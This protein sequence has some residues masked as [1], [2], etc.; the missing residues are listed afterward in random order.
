MQ[1][2][3]RW[4]RRGGLGLL[5]G[6]VLLSIGCGGTGTVSGKV[7]FQDQPLPGGTVIFTNADGKGTKTS[8]IQSDGSYTIEEMPVGQAKIGVE[9]ESINPQG[10]GGGRATPPAAGQAPGRGGPPQS[11]MPPAD[12]VP[13]G[14]DP[15]KIYGRSA[16]GQYVK[17]PDDYADPNSSEQTF[18]VK[19]GA[20]T[21]EIRLK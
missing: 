9:T 15:G 17:I 11:M 13:S 12:K 8:Q 2:R 5:F 14:M 20:N 21:H 18:V 1:L 19:K 7:Y 10:A 16:S 3:S 6:F 4:V